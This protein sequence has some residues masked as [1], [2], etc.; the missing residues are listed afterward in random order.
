MKTERWVVASWCKVMVHH[1]YSIGMH[2]KAVSIQAVTWRCRTD[3][4]VRA[5]GRLELLGPVIDRL[6]QISGLCFEVEEKALATNESYV[7]RI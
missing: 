7:E 5:L 4:D 2:S 6:N 1:G 3:T